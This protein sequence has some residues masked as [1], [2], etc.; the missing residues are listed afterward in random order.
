MGRAIAKVNGTTIAVADKWETVEGNVYFP[1]DSISD[2][3]I[4]SD[5]NLT[6]SCAWKGISSYYNIN[7]DGDVLKDAAWYYPAPKE[8]AKKI[9]DHV[10]F[11]KTK[12]QVSIED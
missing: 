9:K 12:V 8:A 1:P 3:S 2:K 4:F 6:T 11:Y 5:S 10:A 7:I